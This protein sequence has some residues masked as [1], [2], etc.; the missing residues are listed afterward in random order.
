MRS[1]SGLQHLGFGGA[2][3]GLAAQM[4][5]RLVQ[6]TRFIFV[7]TSLQILTI[8]QVLVGPQVSVFIYLKIFLKQ[9]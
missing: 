3:G 2:G 9:S 5:F 1:A 8:L 4:G 6:F 7:V